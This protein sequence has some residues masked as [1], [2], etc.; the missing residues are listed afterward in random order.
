MAD[1]LRHSQV[2]KFARAGGDV[3]VRE[4]DFIA[5]DETVDS[6]GDIVRAHGWQLQRF[7]ANP[8]LLFAHN[9]SEPPIGQVTNI[10]VHGTELRATAR[11][12]DAGVYPKADVIWNAI[13][14]G[15][16]RAVSVG[17]MPT[18]A[19]LEIKDA[20]TDEWT[21]GYEFIGQEL[22]ELSV[23]PIPANPNALAL[24]RSLGISAEAWDRMSMGNRQRWQ[25]VVAT[26]SKELSQ[27]Q[28]RRMRF[29]I[30]PTPR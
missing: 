20:A 14:V 25:P 26:R 13:E 17:F 15:A 4:I 30:T 10:G 7:M 2:S 18:K 3:A 22:M 1:V 6:Y 29:A 5:S 8:V 9:S 16:L 28:T 21:G 12:L 27:M 19:P 23:V 11:F 24:A